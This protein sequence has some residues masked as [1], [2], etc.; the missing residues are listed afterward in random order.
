MDDLRKK[1]ILDLCV[2]PGTTIP[3]ALGASLL[4]LSVVFGGTLAFIGFLCCLAGFGA[5]VT[6]FIFRLGPVSQQAAKE[7]Q[8]QQ[9]KKRDR[10]LDDL[11]TKLTRTRETKDETA[12]RNLRALYTSFCKDYETGK[13]ARSIPPQMLQVI[14][15]IFESCVHQLSRTVELYEQAK[16]VQGNLKTELK[17]D[18][19]DL[20]KEVEKLVESLAHAIN[21]VRAL[22]VQATKSELQNLQRKLASQRSVARATEERVMELD[23]IGDH[24]P[25]RHSEYLD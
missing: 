12:L 7:W 13:L 9:Q 24:D 25:D 1:I 5:L 18:R 15:E 2:T 20:L 17:K 11:D 23:R 22:K 6:N 4:L 21:D 16:Q 3:M 8:K 10:E 14:D 19:S